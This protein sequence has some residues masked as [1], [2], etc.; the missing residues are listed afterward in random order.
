[1]EEDS[2]LRWIPYPERPDRSVRTMG[3]SVTVGDRRLLVAPVH[4]KCCGR[5][6]SWEDERRLEEV[7]L[8]NRAVAEA[9][10]SAGYDGVVIGGDLNL[11]GGSLPI[12]ALGANLDLD[13]SELTILEAYHLHGEE[14]TTWASNRERFVPGRL[15]FLL[16]SD[17]VL[18]AAN[19]FVFDTA[20]LSEAWLAGQALSREA[21]MNASDHLPVVADFVWSG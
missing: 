21:S 2:S 4:L 17:S 8:I 18:T 14:N 11:V 9:M 16:Y 5:I 12:T 19:A 13:Q 10:T 15:D 1:M 3:G 20:D 7:K 6:D